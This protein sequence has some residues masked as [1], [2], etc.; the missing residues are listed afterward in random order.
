VN[1]AMGDRQDGKLFMQ[2]VAPAGDVRL[3]VGSER[4]P[5]YVHSL[6]LKN[7][8]SV[9]SVMLKPCFSEGNTL[10]SGAS[11]TLDIPLPEDDPIAISIMS[12]IIHGRNQGLLTLLASAT[13][14]NIAMAAD[15]YDCAGALAFAMEHWF[16]PKS[17]G[18]RTLARD[19][20]NILLAAY[21]FRSSSA[22]DQMSLALMKGYDKSFMLLAKGGEDI[23]L[24]LQ[25]CC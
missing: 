25:I 4:E 23:D 20:W 17:L 5:I 12:R 7:A 2:D 15:K 9:F 16:N 11:G 24:G 19:Q 3:L 8:S 1:P 10:Q 14:L 21:W 13:I 6:Y 22:F 18:R